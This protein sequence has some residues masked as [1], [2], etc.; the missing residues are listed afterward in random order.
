M[1]F[2]NKDFHQL[3]P[4]RIFLIPRLSDTLFPL[5]EYKIDNLV[6]DGTIEIKEYTPLYNQTLDRVDL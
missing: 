4:D 6:T 1:E 2:P 3:T 5:D